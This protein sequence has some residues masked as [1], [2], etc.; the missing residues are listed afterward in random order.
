MLLLTFGE[1]CYCAVCDQIKIILSCRQESELRKCQIFL[2][3]HVCIK[4]TMR[5]NDSDADDLAVAG[6]SLPE[7]F[8]NER[9]LSS[10]RNGKIGEEATGTNF[11]MLPS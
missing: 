7:T 6:E 8:M 1:L 9:L 2:F 10:R 3:A 5:I 11:I 4:M